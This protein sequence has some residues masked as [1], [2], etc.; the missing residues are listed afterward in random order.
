MRIPSRLRLAFYAQCCLSKNTKYELC[1][2]Q[3]FVFVYLLDGCR[4]FERMLFCFSMY[5][6]YSAVPYGVHAFHALACGWLHGSMAP[7][8]R[9]SQLTP[10]LVSQ[11]QIVVGMQLIACLRLH[12]PLFRTLGCQTKLKLHSIRPGSVPSLFRGQVPL[13]KFVHPVQ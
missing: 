10:S 7:E 4:P 9:Q 3:L 6:G 8:S 5:V 11:V 13:G 1:R 12:V 2:V